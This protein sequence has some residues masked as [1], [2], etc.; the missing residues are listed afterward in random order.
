MII[1]NEND[2]D[3][4]DDDD[5]K[6]NCRGSVVSELGLEIEVVNS[7]PGHD[8]AWFNYFQDR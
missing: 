4:D 5:T 7:I 8:T 3:D 6:Y 1:I 2:D